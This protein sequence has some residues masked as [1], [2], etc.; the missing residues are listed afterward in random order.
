LAAVL[1]SGFRTPLGADLGV[2]FGGDLVTE[3]FNVMGA[4]SLEALAGKLGCFMEGAGL[5]CGAADLLEANF[6][7]RRPQF[8][9]EYCW[10]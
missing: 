8:L 7:A 2:A 9:K 1:L 5:T 4:A 3:V 6:S 10:R